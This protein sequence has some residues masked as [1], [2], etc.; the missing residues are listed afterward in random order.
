LG[1]DLLLGHLFG[2]DGLLIFWRETNVGEVN[3]VHNDMIPRQVIAQLFHGR[4]PDFFPF[5]QDLTDR[6]RRD[7]LFHKIIEG[8]IDHLVGKVQAHFLI[9]VIHKGRIDMEVH[10]PRHLHDLIFFGGGIDLSERMGL[11]P[12]IDLNDGFGHRHFEIES[13]VHD[14]VFD[15]APPEHDPPAAG[16]D[17]HKGAPENDAEHEQHHDDADVSGFKPSG[18]K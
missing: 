5:G 18:F 2:F 14:P 7:H 12:H 9:E 16:G 6:I 11:H 15:A 4:L 1:L 10:H 17:D 8:G 13:L 3:I